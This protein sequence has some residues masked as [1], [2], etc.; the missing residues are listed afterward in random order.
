VGTRAD[1]TSPLLSLRSFRSPVSQT[2]ELVYGRRSDE[3]SSATTLEAAPGQAQEPPRGL[4]G[5]RFSRTAIEAQALCA[6]RRTTPMSSDENVNRL[7]LAYKRRRRPP[8]CKG[9][10]DTQQVAHSHSRYWHL[11]QSTLSDLEAS[12]ALP[13]CLYPPLRAPRCLAI[14]RHERTSTGRMAHGRNQDKP[15]VPLLLSTGHR[16]TDLSASTS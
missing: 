14:Q 7:P 2:L 4:L 8:S 15:R 6:T 5:T 11:P 1:R 13:P 9:T 12:P 16:E 10:T 3:N